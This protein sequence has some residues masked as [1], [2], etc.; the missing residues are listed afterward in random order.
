VETRDGSVLRL[1]RTAAGW[2]V[3][4]VGD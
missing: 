4:G 2:T 3:E 1:Q